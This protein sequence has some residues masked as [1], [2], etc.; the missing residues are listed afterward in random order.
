MGRHER[1]SKPSSATASHLA[2]LLA[3]TALCLLT[4]PAAALAG[5]P[6]VVAWGE[7]E[8]GQLGNS[9]AAST[10]VRTPITGLSGVT[11]LSA[12][13]RDGLALLSDGTVDAWGENDWGQLGVGSSGGLDSCHAAFAQASGYQVPCSTTPVPVKGLAGVTAIASGDQHNLAL[14]SNGTIMAWGDNEYGQLGNGTTQGSDLPVAVSGLSGVKA[15]AAGQ[16]YSLALLK[17]GTV[18]GWGSNA[19]GELGNGIASNHQDLPVA[20]SGLIGVKAIAAW[21]ATSMALLEDGKVMAWGSNY[22]GEL[23]DGTRAGPEYC[24]SGDQLPCSS[25]PV[26]VSGLEGVSAIARG[27]ASYAVMENGT[28]MAWG[29]NVSGQLGVGTM[30]G[31]TECLP[32]NFCS[33]TPVQVSGLEHVTAI[34]G[35]GEHAL[36]LLEDGT[37]MAWGNGWRGQLGD[38]TSE[39][40]DLPV[41]VLGVQDASAV[42]AGE[43]YSL[44]YGVATQ[45]PPFVTGVSPERGT[46]AGGTTVNITGS[47]FDEVTAVKF[48]SADAASFKVNAEASITA[49]SPAGTGTVDVTVET[50]AGVSPATTADHF[51]YGP[52]IT[53][54]EPNT[55]PA[56]GGSTVTITGSGFTGASAV[57]FG[58]HEATSFTVDSD[59][60]ITAVSPAGSGTVEVGVTTPDGS[61]TFNTSEEFTY[62]AP[63]KTGEAPTI[64]GASVSE[65][66]ERG[67]KLEAQINPNGLRT[68]YELVLEYALCQSPRGANCEVWSAKTVGSGAIAAGDEP[69]AVSALATNLSPGYS[70]TYRV[71][72][73]NGA[74]T[75]NGQPQ[76]FK[77]LQEGS[78]P[79]SKAP[80]IVSLSVSEVTERDATLEAQ[81]DTEGLQTTYQF[82]LWSICGGR[83]VCQI[84]INYPLP[85]GQLLPSFSAQR[86]SLD[87]GSAGAALQPG[88]TYFYSLTATNT[89]GTTAG[90][91]RAFSTPE[92]VFYPLTTKAPAGSAGSSSGSGAPG[93]QASGPP[94][95]GLTS[96]VTASTGSPRAR[97]R[98][99]VRHRRKRGHHKRRGQPRSKS[100]RHRRR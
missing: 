41:P 17:N 89:A 3:S 31:P 23:G 97:A 6:S 58:P 96:P 8:V 78:P 33:T 20:V 21:G 80:A 43:E 55:G 10:Q 82:T 85:S 18:M 4:A 72:A 68:E 42:A 92:E 65:I 75:T 71:I 35:G 70:Y 2:W 40:S 59:D 95:L 64:D 67:A 22:F 46:P 9:T 93:P 77:T 86:V 61:T 47:D 49:V 30:T 73:T 94:A 25:V 5:S 74:G 98:A 37:V 54:L 32:I 12:G 56:V 38:G 44:A 57:N 100:A 34:A 19:E 11:A 24:A 16:N 39:S 69:E 36:A 29:T 48:G 76:G 60:S 62:E 15:I 26:P 52:T 51:T 1:R 83:G 45:L 13:R 53:R 81:I 50:K 7:N 79:T 28:V 66:T 99:T 90:E 14:L 88:G 87:L 84:V 27:G 63:P 91:N